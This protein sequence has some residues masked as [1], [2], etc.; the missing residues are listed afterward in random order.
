M[1]LMQLC[2]VA[3]ACAPSR[4]ET[5][6]SSLLPYQYEARTDDDHYYATLIPIESGKDT[7]TFFWS[8]SSGPIFDVRVLRGGDP[9]GRIVMFRKTSS[10]IVSTGLN[11][12]TLEE[13]NVK[14]WVSEASG[15]SYREVTQFKSARTKYTLVSCDGVFSKRFMSEFAQLFN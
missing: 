13:D 10:G 11:I 14:D 15:T 4:P 1:I 8:E 2:A 9:T 5:C 7:Q 6:D 3:A 12:V